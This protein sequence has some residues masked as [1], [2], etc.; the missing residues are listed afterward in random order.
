MGGVTKVTGLHGT[1][2]N[3]SRHLARTHVA[4]LSQPTNDLST[5]P[6]TSA[7]PPRPCCRVENTYLFSD[8]IVFET[9]I[10]GSS[11]TEKITL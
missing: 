1:P 6:P 5:P 10:R 3:P 8:N 11:L 7:K 9:D 2:T 4:T